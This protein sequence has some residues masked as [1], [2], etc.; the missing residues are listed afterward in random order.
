VTNDEMAMAMKDIPDDVARHILGALEADAAS[1]LEDAIGRLGR[2]R[3]RDVETAQR[4][5]IEELAQLDKAGEV[6]IARPGEVID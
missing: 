5:V 4:E 1:A 2:V 6:V 3:R